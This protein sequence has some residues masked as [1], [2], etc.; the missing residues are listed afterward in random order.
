MYSSTS[1]SHPTFFFLAINAT[2]L[3]DI[4]NPTTFLRVQQTHG[5]AVSRAVLSP[6]FSSP[7]PTQTRSPHAGV[8]HKSGWAFGLGLERLCMVLFQI[9]DIR[10]FWSTDPR[11]LIQFSGGSI[12]PFKPYSRYPPCLRDMSFWLPAETEGKKAWHEN[13]YCE[14]VRDVAGD[15]I[16]DVALVR[17]WRYFGLTAHTRTSSAD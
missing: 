5:T 2:L 14:I 6:E 16:E 11:F 8:P 17:V 10:L 13:D 15:L 4:I 9:P 12:T 1:S 7:T 3:P